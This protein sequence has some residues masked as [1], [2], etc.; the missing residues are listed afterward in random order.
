M[1]RLRGTR[2]SDREL[3]TLAETGAVLLDGGFPGIAD[4][5]TS[6]LLMPYWD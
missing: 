4:I 5:P 3:R 6:Q 2:P 1:R